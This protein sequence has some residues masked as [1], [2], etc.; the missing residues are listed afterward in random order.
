MDIGQ[1]NNQWVDT[2]YNH[3][4]YGTHSFK[5]PSKGIYRVTVKYQIYGTGGPADKITCELNKTY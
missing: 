5:L 4:Y 1:S 2:V 3:R